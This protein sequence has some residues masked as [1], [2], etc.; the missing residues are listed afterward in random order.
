MVGIDLGRILS[1]SAKS[2]LFGL[3]IVTGFSPLPLRVV[4]CTRF[5]GLKFY[6]FSMLLGYIYSGA[7][8]SQSGA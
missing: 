3:F 7:Q 4:F 2:F 5:S 6:S 1:P 8:Y